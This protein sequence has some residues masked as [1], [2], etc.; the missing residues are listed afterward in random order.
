GIAGFF[1]APILLGALVAAYRVYQ[2]QVHPE[3]VAQADPYLKNMAE[4]CK[5]D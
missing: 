3:L 2:E 5:T 1:A 4:S